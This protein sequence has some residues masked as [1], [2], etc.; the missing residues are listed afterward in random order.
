M[1]LPLNAAGF[2][3]VR[4]WHVNIFAIISGVSLWQSSSVSYFNMR[5]PMLF[6][7]MSNLEELMLRQIKLLLQH[8]ICSVG[9]LQHNKTLI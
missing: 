3:E 5:R 8:Y 9:K 2:L 1:S 6:S 4:Y 7:L